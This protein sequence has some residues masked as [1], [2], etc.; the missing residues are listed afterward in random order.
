MASSANLD[1]LSQA[2]VDLNNLGEPQKQVLA[3]LTPAELDTMIS[4][5]ERLEATGEVEG[6]AK[7]TNNVGASFF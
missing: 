4:I 1:K 2:G 6:F 3:S 7:G 5:K